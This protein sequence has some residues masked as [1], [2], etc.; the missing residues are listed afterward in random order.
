MY[1]DVRTQGKMTN[2]G[3]KNTFFRDLE[4]AE[5]LISDESGMHF[6]MFWAV[7]GAQLR[8]SKYLYGAKHS[9]LQLYAN[10]DPEQK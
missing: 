9:P 1:F 10:F 3:E 8:K 2:G 4:I 7:F 6:C 5:I